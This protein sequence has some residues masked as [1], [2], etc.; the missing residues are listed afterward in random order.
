MASNPAELRE[1]AMTTTPVFPPEGGCDCRQ[2]RCRMRS[3]RSIVHRCHCRWC[4]RESGSAFVLN[5]MIEADRVV[6]ARGEPGT[7][8]VPAYYRREDHWP[9]TSIAGFEQPIPASRAMQPRLVRC[10]TARDGC[11]CARLP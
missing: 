9:Y 2:V 6:A 3:A 10:A 11:R 1:L 4:Q 7:P 5:T 8:A